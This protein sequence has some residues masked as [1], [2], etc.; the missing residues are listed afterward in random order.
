MIRASAM[1]QLW[2]DDVT[3]FLSLLPQA[4]QLRRRVDTSLGP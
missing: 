1:T 2:L 4:S 3:P